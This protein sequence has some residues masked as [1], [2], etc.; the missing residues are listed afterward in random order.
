MTL[1]EIIHEIEYF[2][3]TGIEAVGFVSPSHF[4]PH[5]KTIIHQLHADGYKP[6]TVYNTNSFDKA[7]IIKSFEG[8]IDVYLPDLK[9]AEAETSLNWSDSSTYPAV[10]KTAIMEMYRQ[11]GST[12]V[13]G[14]NNQAVTGLIIRH[15][16]LPG[17]VSESIQLF[18]WVAHQLSPSVHV[19]LMSQYYPTE[20]VMGHPVLGRPILKDEY[21]LVVKAME[22]LGFHKGWIQEFNSSFVYRPDFC[23]S[24]PFSEY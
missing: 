21:N 23:N 6:I 19:S 8:L 17:R 14:D 11:K 16:V 22:D 3:N 20:G 12:L 7:E 10:S 1:T 18:E 9:Y 13:L 24:N 4:S 15:L 2:L 5:V